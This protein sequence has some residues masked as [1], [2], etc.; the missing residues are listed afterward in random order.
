MKLS[1]VVAYLNM[2]DSTDMDPSYGNITDKLDNI[3]H[4]VKNRD[5]HYHSATSD[6]DEKLAGVKHSIGKFDQSLHALKQQLQNDVDQLS[7]EY[8]AESWKRYE[9]EMC[10]ETV[11]HLINRKL[12]IEFDDHERLRNTIKN[13]T[14]WR[15]P[16][17]VLG[18]RRETFIEDMVP[19]DP[20]Y[21]VDHD[22][23]L[24]NVAMS[25]FTQEYQR[26]L[27]PYVINDWKDT[28]IFTALPSNQFGLVFA[29]NYFNWK[30]IEM[31]EKFLTEIYQKLRPGG[32]LVFT[33]NECD[34]WYGVGAVENAWMCYT[35][36]SRIQTIARNL[37]YKIIE[38]CTGAGDIAWF[39]MHKPGEVRS[40]RGG[41][42][43]AKVIRQE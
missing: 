6:L 22:R 2:L 15:L 17:M 10:F 37:G 25:P 9:Q 29:Y 27:R 32:A 5:L 19:M 31:I 41:Q 21:L 20:L 3:L 40:L 18:A 36:G 26:R 24:I 13:Y 7:P 33:Y 4:A 30:P 35:P 34:N 39:E 8:Y 14:D 43:L 12:T 38:Q 1:Q 23:E 28:E 42:V 11:E 16:G